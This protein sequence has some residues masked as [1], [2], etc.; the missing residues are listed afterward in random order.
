MDEGAPAPAPAPSPRRPIAVVAA[1]PIELAG[2]RRA[3]L[4]R[5][6]L[7]L[8]TARAWVGIADRAA[9]AG[10]GAERRSAV[11]AALGMGQ[12]AVERSLARLFAEFP[13]AAVVLVG[14]AGGC[15]ADAR[16][17]DAIA[18]DPMVVEPEVGP[19][20]APIEGRAPLGADRLA[21][22][23]VLRAAGACG[24]RIRVA[25]SVTINVIAASARAKDSLGRNRGAAVCEMEN[26]FA[27]RFC[28][29]RGVPFAAVRVVFDAVGEPLPALAAAGDRAI[30]RVLWERPRRVGG[31]PRLA[32]RMLR[33]RRTLDPLARAIVGELAAAAPD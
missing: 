7:A 24:V 12:A 29:A 10:P 15:T 18:C 22:D 8:G 20:G 13:P 16:P 9:A 28:R 17:G 1:L 26:F 4:C 30:W 27:A 31:I 33:V 2:A 21:L 11:A 23:A 6:K 25:P 5:K 19:N 32:L 14:L 3:I